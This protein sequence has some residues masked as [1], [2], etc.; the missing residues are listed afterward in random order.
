M[1]DYYYSQEGT[2]NV[3]MVKVFGYMFLGLLVTALSAIG[4]FYLFVSGT[5]SI[6]SYGGVTLISSLAL[7]VLIFVAQFYCLKNKSGGLIVYSLYAMAMGVLMSSLMLTYSIQFLGYVFLCTAG[8][9]GAMAL[10]GLISKR[11]NFS[12]GMFGI[13]ALF[14]ILTLSLVNIFLQSKGI[15]YLISYLGLAAMLAITAFD[16]QRAKQLAMSGSM[17]E[18]LAIYMALQLYTDFIYIFVSINFIC[19]SS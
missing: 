7:I 19:F 4:L 18:G 3:S 1:R 9:F 2:Q 16:I 12:L 11:P 13:G 15:Y 10:Y 17:T 6:A 8:S 5:I 14:G